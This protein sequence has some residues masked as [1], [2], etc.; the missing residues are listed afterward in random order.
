MVTVEERE[1][2]KQT[3]L[4]KVTHE[5]EALIDAALDACKKIDDV[6]WETQVSQ[7]LS[8]SILHVAISNIGKNMDVAAF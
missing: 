7:F 5:A 1:T 4:D 3:F 2:T 6:T 8:W